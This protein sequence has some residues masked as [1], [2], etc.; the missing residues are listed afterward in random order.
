MEKLAKTV[1]LAV[2]G[3]GY[4]GRKV[5]EE[6]L[7]LARVDSSFNI[8]HVCDPKEANLK[9]CADS[10]HLDSDKLC[11]DYEA[12]LKSP[13]VDAV[14]ICTPN[15]THYQ[16]GLQALYKGKNVLMEKPLALSQKDG[17][18]LCAAAEARHLCLQVGHIYRFSNAL[19]KLRA[20]IDDGYFGKL[21]YLKLQWTTWMPSPLGRDIIFDLGPHPIDILNFLLGKWPV[22]VSCVGKSYRRPSL[23]EVAYFYLDFGE[24]L[25]SLVEL[26]WLHPGKTRELTVMGSQ[27]AATVDCMRQRIHVLE[28]NTIFDEIHHFVT[29]IR[30]ESNHKN[31]GPVGAKLVSVLENLQTS[32]REE[33]PVKVGIEQ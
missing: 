9:N 20:L 1:N 26:S 6:Y 31:P 18:N 32:L 8:A 25:M 19:K 17:W 23:E 5:V 30:D 7:N 22:K 28:N 27:R 4:W 24:N 13:D 16:I 29:S 15:E 21:Y 10:L 12:V 14:H 3:A 33:R 11:T 2:L